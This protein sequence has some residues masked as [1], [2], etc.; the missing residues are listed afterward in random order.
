M[1]VQVLDWCKRII[2]RLK[3]TNPFDLRPWNSCRLVLYHYAFEDSVLLHCDVP[4]IWIALHRITYD[5]DPD[6][7][8]LKPSKIARLEKVILHVEVTSRHFT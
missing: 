5:R 6:Y 4:D 2:I 8:T 1:R 3:G 7:I